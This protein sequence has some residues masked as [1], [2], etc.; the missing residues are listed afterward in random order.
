MSPACRS[1]GRSGRTQGRAFVA[2]INLNAENNYKVAIRARK[3]GAPAPSTR[4]A[5]ASSGSLARVLTESKRIRLVN[6]LTAS[7]QDVESDTSDIR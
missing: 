6:M 3:G 7:R 2:L 4:E 1:R 5:A